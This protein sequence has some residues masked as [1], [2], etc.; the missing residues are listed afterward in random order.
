MNHFRAEVG[1]LHRLVVGER[2]D[3]RRI[4]DPAR[5]G[6]EHAVNV[7]P[8]VDF[9]RIK[10]RPEN[11]GGK[12]TTVTAERGLH[13]ARVRGDEAGDDQGALEVAVDQVRELGP[14]LRPLHA[15]AQRTPFHDHDPAGVD[16]LDRTALAAMLLIEAVEELGRPD[17]AVADDEIAH[18]ARGRAGELHR[19]KNA[20]EVVAVAVESRE[21]KPRGLRGEE[22]LRNFRVSRAQCTELHAITVILLLRERHE[23]EQSVGDALAC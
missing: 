6:G 21:I 8:D 5:I 1:E 9:R 10:Q 14:G 20:F 23:A 4:R 12:V 13:P 22:R 18:V 15:G 16:P 2:V 7:G 19:M 11:G 17:L 3:H